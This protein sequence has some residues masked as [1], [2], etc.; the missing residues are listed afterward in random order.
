MVSPVT[1]R[2]VFALLAASLL[3]LIGWTTDA[4][5]VA[6][7]PDGLFDDT[8]G[9]F[10]PDA[11]EWVLLTDFEDADTDDDGVGDYI[12]AVQGGYP[13]TQDAVALPADDEMRVLATTRDDDN[14][15]SVL[16]VHAMF[17]L[18]NGL[19]TKLEEVVPWVD[20]KGQKYPLTGLFDKTPLF[21][22]ILDNGAQGTLVVISTPVASEEVGRNLMPFTFGVSARLG[23]RRVSSSAYY[24]DV[25]GRSS[26]LAALDR[27]R[28]AFQTLRKTQQ[29]GPF[30]F[31]NQVCAL[32]L[33]V[34]GSSPAGTVVRV[35]SAR[36]E[37]AHALRCSIR[38]TA[39]N[40]TTLVLPDGM[41]TITGR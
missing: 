15:D 38:C 34:I 31:V 12:E 41:S 36:C 1:H 24:L 8:D 29:E 23:G 18:M 22:R 4:K 20:L 3:A 33:T 35:N 5:T 13:I 32:R 10:I 17:R 9:D 37:P 19:D 27:D 39:V 28:S 30:E 7:E 40:E 25:G 6:A 26:V 21:W 14:G 11:L 2:I 16:W